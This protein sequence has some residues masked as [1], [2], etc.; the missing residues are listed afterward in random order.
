[1]SYEKFKYIMQT[2]VAFSEKKNKIADFFEKEIMEDSWCIITLGNPIEDVLI[3]MLAD[4]FECWYTFREG[5]K[6]FDWWI[7][8]EGNRYKGF[9]NEIADWIYNIDDVK[10]MTIADSQPF[11]F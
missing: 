7:I 10:K 11:L 8:E 5:V 2:L 3:N 9:E 4:E 6:E 1:M